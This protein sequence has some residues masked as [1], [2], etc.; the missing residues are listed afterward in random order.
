[1]THWT[2]LDHMFHFLLSG[3]LSNS[4]IYNQ[5][6]KKRQLSL[7]SLQDDVAFG[8]PLASKVANDVIF[9]PSQ[10]IYSC[11]LSGLSPPHAEI[12][13]SPLVTYSSQT[14]VLLQ[15]PK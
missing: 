6:E 13:Y 12:Q 10:I 7:R 1:M 14:P 5:E 3:A 2:A 11:C 15:G 9:P 8:F 4:Y